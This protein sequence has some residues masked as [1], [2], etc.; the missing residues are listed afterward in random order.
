MFQTSFA[1]NS[2]APLRQPPTRATWHGPRL[3]APFA[4]TAVAVLGWVASAAAMAQPV[5]TKTTYTYATTQ[6]VA[7][8]ADIYSTATSPYGQRRPAVVFVHGGSWVCGNRDAFGALPRQMAESYGAVA[9][10]VSYRLAP[11]FGSVV[12]ADGRI[13]FPG[14]ADGCT[15]ATAP[16]DDLGLPQNRTPF[17]AQVVDL[18]EFMWQLRIHADALQVDRHRIAVVGESAGGH[19]AGALAAVD[20]VPAALPT[21]LSGQEVY[22]R[23]NAV[24]SVSGPWN[25]AAADLPD[26]SV[27]GTLRNLFGGEPGAAQ[28]EAASPTRYLPGNVSPLSGRPFP[29]TLFIHGAADTLVP[30]AQSI[31]ACSRMGPACAQGQPLI[32]QTSATVNPHDTQY[33]LQQR[34]DAFL[35]VLAQAVGGKP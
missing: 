17:P 18:R 27:H 31:D 19:L 28:L 9:I 10:T 16:S 35:S 7:L 33:L 32:V 26:P 20:A 3:R 11:I 2:P 1:G 13:S 34:L 22:S 4:I 8:K 25:L 23:P 6:G 14:T 15:A 12:D 29:P 24:V 30:P 21:G 5:A